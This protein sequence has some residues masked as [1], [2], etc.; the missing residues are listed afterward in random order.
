MYVNITRSVDDEIIR[1][2]RRRADALGT[3]VNQLV[4]DYLKELAGDVYSDA[5]AAEFERLSRIPGGRPSGWK[6]NR[7]EIHERRSDGR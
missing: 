7:D 2:A 4:K 5:D 3:N 6:L 1:A